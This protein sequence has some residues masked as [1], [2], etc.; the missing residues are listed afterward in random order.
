[1]V[2]MPRVEVNG[3][4]L[5]YTL[6]GQPDAPVLMMS[7]S[8][9]TT[10]EM[11]QPQ[12]AA[13]ESRFHLLRY[14]MRGH[15]KSEVTEAA[16]SIGTLGQDVV[17]LLDELRIEKVHFCG[18][19]IGGVIGQWLGANAP[20]RLNSLVLCNTAARIGTLESWN[21][22][23]AAVEHGGLASIVDAVIQR[24]FTPAF[25]LASPGA[26][27]P[28]RSMVLATNPRGYVLLCAALR[29]MDQRKLV[30]RIRLPTC[31]IAGNHDPATT[32]DD[33]KFLQ[34]KIPG[35]TLVP[36]PV[37]HI[38]NVEAAEQF[39]AALIEFLEGVEV[40]LRPGSYDA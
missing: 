38:S 12:L 6:S 39:N 24:W 9:G 7:N 1:M 21:E 35:A 18:L 8:L 19:S 32:L 20:E 16:C 31:V 29:D 17:S 15:G 25:R 2:P 28:L 37:A 27:A 4:R 23:I 40:A 30:E 34:D 36:L 26:V 5:F 33:A 13:L 3:A 10:L 22:R 14:D 11:W